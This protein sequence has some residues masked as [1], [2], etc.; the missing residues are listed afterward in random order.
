MNRICFVDFKVE[1]LVNRKTLIRM[2][3]ENVKIPL[4]GRMSDFA[5]ATFMHIDSL[6]QMNAQI[7]VCLVVARVVINRFVYASLIAVDFPWN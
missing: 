2:K 6:E 1:H 5:D 3:L 7:M 4:N